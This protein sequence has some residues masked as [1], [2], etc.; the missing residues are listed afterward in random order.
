MITNKIW[1][2]CY[3]PQV[4]QYGAEEEEDSDSDKKPTKKGGKPNKDDK[5]DIKVCCLFF[6][7]TNYSSIGISVNL[8]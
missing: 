8:S 4:V 2:N 1:L 7:K 3:K 6:Y 5:G